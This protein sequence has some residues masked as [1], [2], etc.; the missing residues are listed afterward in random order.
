[1]ADLCCNVE[2][3]L[4]CKMVQKEPVDVHPFFFVIFSFQRE[5]ILR[6][7]VE[8]DILHGS[9]HTMQSHKNNRALNQKE[10]FECHF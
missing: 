7:I 2:P 6:P 4:I 5:E 1:M 8:Q 10:T 9:S 3:L